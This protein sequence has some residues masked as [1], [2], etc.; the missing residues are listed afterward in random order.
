MSGQRRYTIEKPKE[1]SVSRDGTSS[2]T[3]R[4]PNA[5]G[6]L[7]VLVEPILPGSITVRA[8]MVV[9][10]GRADADQENGQVEFSLPRGKSYL[11]EVSHPGYGTEKVSSRQLT[12]QTITRVRGSTPI[13]VSQTQVIC[14]WERRSWLMARVRTVVDASGT[15]LV[16]EIT[17]GGHR[18]T[19]SHPEYNDFE[20]SF[21]VRAAGEEVRYPRIPLTRVAR[22]ELNGPPGVL[23]MIDGA[24][25]GKIN[26]SGKLRINYEIE[27]IVERSI[28][29]ELVGFQPWSRRM[30]LNPGPRGDRHRIESGGDLGRGDRLL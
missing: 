4:Q 29:A 22:L 7:V 27:Q 1:R 2:T 17:P 9:E 21:E 11:I 5:R 20:D 14:R 3:S 10:L 12:G 15:A 30:M 13:G 28:T 8:S 26:E 16:T 19:I 24:L 18:L 23:V 25:Q 6:L